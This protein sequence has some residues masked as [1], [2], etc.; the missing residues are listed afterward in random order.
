MASPQTNDFNVPHFPP[1]T[2]F[3]PRAPPPP[4]FRPPP[5]PPPPSDNHPT[6]IVIVLIS[7]G[8]LLFLAFLA[9]ALFCFLKKKKKKAVQEV[10]IIHVDEH[11]KV[12]EAIIPG[13]YGKQSVILSMEDDVHLDEVIAKNEKFGHAGLHAKAAQ[14]ES[15]STNKER[16][17]SSSSFDQQQF[18]KSL[19]H[20]SITPS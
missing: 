3:H 10:E 1:P 5:P 4:H 2:P 15:G 6:V 17:S 19:D 16:G 9:A 18:D 8:S 11:R 20:K 13:P 14:G 7:F 12:N